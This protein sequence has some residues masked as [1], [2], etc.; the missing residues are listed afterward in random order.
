MDETVTAKH[1]IRG[2]RK[3]VDRNVE[4]EVAPPNLAPRGTPVQVRNE[5]RNDVHARIGYVELCSVDPAG[6]PA[7]RVEQRSHAEALESVV[8]LAGNTC[9]GAAFR[10]QPGPRFA[11]A[12]QI[13]RVDTLEALLEAEAGEGFAL[14]GKPAVGRRRQTI[15]VFQSNPTRMSNSS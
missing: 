1:R 15:F 2:N 9:S 14:G 7:R 13:R 3:S 12:P 10:A 4:L 11:R 8:K 6:V 5:F